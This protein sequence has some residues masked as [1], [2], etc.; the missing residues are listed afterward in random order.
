MGFGY[1]NELNLGRYTYNR[2]RIHI[3]DRHRI[4]VKLINRNFMTKRILNLILTI[5]L[6]AVAFATG[7]LWQE[8]E[9]TATT[10]EDGLVV[11]IDAGHGGNDPGKIGINGAEEKDINLQ[12]AFKLQKCL[13]A[14]GV[15]VVLTRDEDRG[16]YEDSDTNK[17]T[18]DMKKRCALIEQVGADVVISIHQNSYTDSGVSGAQ[19]FYY[20]AS[21][22]GQQLAGCIQNRILTG[23]EGIN[24]RPIKGND[25]YYLLLN[26]PCPTVIVECGFLSNEAEAAL[27]CD[28]SYQQKLAEA[29][30]S[31]T[32]DFLNGNY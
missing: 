8:K 13:E 3:F 4:I 10:A 31:G 11:V 19:V 29:I 20:N 16:L 6:L 32:L 18:A 30:C 25:S 5:L 2:I 22:R 27:L 26:T 7:F 23:I 15:Q 1:G 28:E 17:K 21:D 14:Q 12:I 9:L 24:E